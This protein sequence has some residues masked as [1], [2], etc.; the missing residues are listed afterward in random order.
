MGKTTTVTVS[1][2]TQLTTSKITSYALFLQRQPGSDA[3]PASLS[4]QVQ[5]PLQ[6]VVVAPEGA[7]VGNIIQFD[8]AM[9]TH[10]YM[11]V[12]VARE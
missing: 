1:Y 7:V 5:K 6:A 11:A 2:T 4:L 12:E 3:Y 10:Q 9:D 8:T